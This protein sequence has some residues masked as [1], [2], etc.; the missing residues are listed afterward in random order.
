MLIHE[1]F[2]AT[3]RCLPEAE[4]FVMGDRTLT[5]GESAARVDALAAGLTSL[6]PA[7][8][9]VAL[10]TSKSIETV[11]LMLACLRAGMSYVPIDPASPIARRRFI[12]RDSN[13]RALVVDARTATDWGDELAAQP[14]LDLVISPMPLAALAP[15]QMSVDY[16]AIQGAHQPAA[17]R[18]PAPDDLAYI[19]YTSGSTGDPKGVQITH[20]NASAFVEWAADA[21]D[22]RP[23]DRVAVH[24]PLHF[25]LPVFDLY[26]SLA[27]GATVYP[28]DEKT[29]LFPEALL[30]FLQSRQISVLY[31]VPSALTAL[32]NRSTLTA[33]MLPALRLLLY[34]GEEFQPTPLA[35]LMSRLPAAR[36]FNLYGPIETNV[37]TAFEVLP[38]HLHHQR[39]PIG[40]PISNT[41]IFLI[42]SAG[43]VIEGAN[44]EGE[45]VVHGPS[46]SPGYL[47]QS[48]RTASSRC[49]LAYRGQRW[50][51]YRTGDFARWDAQGLLHFLGR[52][53]ALIKT[54][55]FR[56]DLGDVEATLMRHPALAE[57]GVVAQ[58]H[59]D[60][61]N[62]L[63]GFVVPR[64]GASVDERELLAWCRAHIPAYMVPCQIHVCQQL[65]KTSTGKLARRELLSQDQQPAPG[66]LR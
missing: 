57:V 23:G 15:Q 32:V 26:V 14:E 9:R 38:E 10:N 65:P 40:A 58:A 52:R 64:A 47:N 63:Y 21:F 44:C 12:L 41:C 50:S 43:Q 54:R 20:R 13:A 61:T 5:Y 48:E 46:V 53:D 59:P 37:V 8:A 28:I 19:L 16:L 36:F 30:R 45:I 24:A 2:F 51:C 29:T 55:G 39:I 11:L 27:R 22:L 60:Y 66:V 49:E 6:L 42:D 25:D 7:E 4:A 1:R 56:V 17:L 34:A 3:A 31:A 62:L 33:G 35:A 18:Q